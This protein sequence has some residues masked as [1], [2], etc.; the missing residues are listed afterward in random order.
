MGFHYFTTLNRVY[1][2]L[3]M[4]GGIFK[5]VWKVE[6]ANAKFN[7]Y[8]HR[9]IMLLVLLPFIYSRTLFYVLP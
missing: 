5:T 3:E 4:E 1:N 2:R 8:Y 9:F 6:M 7:L